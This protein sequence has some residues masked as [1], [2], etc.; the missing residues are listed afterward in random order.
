MGYK[1]R[2]LRTRRLHLHRITMPLTLKEAGYM[3]LAIESV[4]Y[5]GTLSTLLCGGI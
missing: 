3:G 2:L 1:T 4:A 5:G